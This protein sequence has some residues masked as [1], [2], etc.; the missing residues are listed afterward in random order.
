M[1]AGRGGGK[2]GGK[3]SIGRRVDGR[4]WWLKI[5][6]GVA[7]TE[8]GEWLAGGGGRKTCNFKVYVYLFIFVLTFKYRKP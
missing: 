6:G 5:V 3:Q 2:A 1:T 7:A 4:R 8:G